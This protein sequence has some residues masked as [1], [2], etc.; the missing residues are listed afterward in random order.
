MWHCATKILFRTPCHCEFSFS[1]LTYSLSGFSLCL[2]YNFVGRILG[3]RGLT[4]KQLEAETGC[5]IMVRGKSSMRDKKKV[6]NKTKKCIKSLVSQ[7]QNKPFTPEANPHFSTQT[8]KYL[9]V[10]VVRLFV[11]KNW[12]CVL[13]Y[14][15]IT[16]TAVTT[17]SQQPCGRKHE[18]DIC[19]GDSWWLHSDT[20][21]GC[22]RNAARW[23][24]QKSVV[25]QA[26]RAGPVYFWS[27]GQHLKKLKV[28]RCL[29]S[30]GATAETFC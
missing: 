13:G 4:A 22:L 18:A 20:R 2:Q 7:S 21:Y 27:W 30:T 9:A 29:K 26:L 25:K 1:L 12:P 17:T 14:Y 10:P 5:K 16:E 15:T 19:S 3:P 8:S 11:H 28:W 23:E 6:S 24:V